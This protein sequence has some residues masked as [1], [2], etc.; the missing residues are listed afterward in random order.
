MKEIYRIDINKD[1]FT[2]EDAKAAAK[3]IFDVQQKDFESITHEK[4]YQKFLDALT[5]H[6]VDKKKT[7]KNISSLGKLQTL[8]MRVYYEQYKELDR[9]LNEIIDDLK[10]VNQTVRR[11]YQTCVA[12]IR[13]QEDLNN[14]GHHDKQIL[15]LLL[16][17]YQSLSGNNDILRK[18]R[19]GIAKTMSEQ[20]PEGVF[21]NEQLATIG[22]PK[23]FYRCLME[24]CALDDSFASVTM[25][26]NIYD[27]INYLNISPFEKNNVETTL[28]SELESFGVEY[29]I[30]KYTNTF[31]SG[32]AAFTD[33]DDIDLLDANSVEVEENIPLEEISDYPDFEEIAI[34][35][36]LHIASGETQKYQNKIIHLQ[37]LIE[38]EGT[39]EF[40]GCEIHYGETEFPPEINLSGKAVLLMKSCTVVCH[41]KDG[42]TLINAATEEVPKFEHC[43]FDR[44]SDFLD[45]STV[46]M[47]NCKINDASERFICVRKGL[48]YK[49]NFL[50]EKETEPSCENHIIRCAKELQLSECLVNGKAALDRMKVFSSEGLLVSDSTFRNAAN[51]FSGEGCAKGCTFEHCESVFISTETI[52]LTDCCFNACTEI[53]YTSGKAL[54]VDCKFVQCFNSLIDARFSNGGSK[55]E[56]CEFEQ[57]ENRKES[58]EQDSYSSFADAMIVFHSNK[59]GT[60]STIYKSIFRNATTGLGYLVVGNALEKLKHPVAIIEKCRFDGCVTDRKDGK[61]IR[62]F[63]DY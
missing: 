46:E 5:L 20:L 42:H 63:C 59:N 22:S 37:S 11:L 30:D 18:Y 29:L 13:P 2:I 28:K 16:A 61:L 9:D 49:C 1:V 55:I 6:S 48:F 35:N 12:Q 58:C 32:V 60:S 14:L 23:V 36:I 51:L 52:E 3:A 54:L 47:L 27:A 38:C 43:V 31:G 57:W 53:I 44:C 50:F 25:P 21:K 34:H 8:F 15:L 41:R 39:L 62:E 17:E 33:G 10:K 24:M 19:A 40:D 4:W 26:E 56:R 7:V 45:S